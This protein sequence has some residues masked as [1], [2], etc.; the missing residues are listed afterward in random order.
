M[1]SPILQKILVIFL[2]LIGEGIAIYSEIL[3]SKQHVIFSL[4]FWQVF[5]KMFIV[6][7]VGGGL[8]IL[9]YILGYDA[10]RNIWIVGVISI[11]SILI[12]EPILAWT[13][14][15]ESPTRGALIGLI[16]GALGFAASLFL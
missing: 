10:F 1:V 13:I 11:T 12:L 8:L 14:F 5:L 15:K 9:G 3:A 2:I 16:F 6:M 7:T 4:P